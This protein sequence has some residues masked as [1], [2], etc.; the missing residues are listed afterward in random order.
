MNILAIVPARGGSKGVPG[1][2]I[3]PL[4]GRPL[5][6]YTSE[7][8]NSTRSVFG[9]VILSTDDKEIALVGEA[10][11][12]EVP[13]LRPSELSQD[14]TPM[15]P[16]IKHALNWAE[17]ASGPF[18]VVA[19]LQPTQ[20]LRSASHI[21]EAVAL[22]GNRQCDSVVSVVA[23][24]LHMSPDYVMRIEDGPQ[25]VP[26]LDVGTRVIRRQDA[27]PAY[28][29]DGTI[30]LTKATNVRDNDSLYGRICYP[31]VISGATS[32]TIDTEADWQEA[33]RRLAGHNA[34][35][36]REVGEPSSSRGSGD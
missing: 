8:V 31:M 34:C 16:V 26:F 14:D 18:D 36:T 21:H 23:L 4:C 13:F 15:L 12:L 35:A 6:A 24:P 10:L 29:R 28:V 9:R 30:Y 3:R 11:G 27:R 20:P 2:N 5:L 7:V 32:L 25:L 17:R 22:I 33:E 1:K 19:I